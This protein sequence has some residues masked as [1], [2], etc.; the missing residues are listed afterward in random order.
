MPRPQENSILS[1]M[2][3]PKR[4][5][6]TTDSDQKT[7][8]KRQVRRMLHMLD[9][10]DQPPTNEKAVQNELRQVGLEQPSQ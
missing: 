6:E 9:V 3:N 8:E 10:I 1:K 4:R 2:Q 7:K 5:R